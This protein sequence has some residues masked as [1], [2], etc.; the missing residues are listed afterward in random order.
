MSDGSERMLDRVGALA[1]IAAALLLVALVMV[2][3][4]LPGPDRQ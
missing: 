4:A 1:G 2:V 3:P